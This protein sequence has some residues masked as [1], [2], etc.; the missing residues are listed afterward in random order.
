M[1]YAADR[2]VFV[3][4]DQGDEQYD[5]IASDDV[6]VP[7]VDHYRQLAA[8]IL[9]ELRNTLDNIPQISGRYQKSQRLVYHKVWIGTDMLASEQHA[10]RLLINLTLVILQLEDIKRRHVTPEVLMTPKF[11][12]RRAVVD[13]CRG[14]LLR[15]PR[16]LP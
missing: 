9:R 13:E 8:V 11:H 1:K 10:Q 4:A 7:V 5:G 3:F 2:L 16:R 15:N 6:E 12:L 14:P